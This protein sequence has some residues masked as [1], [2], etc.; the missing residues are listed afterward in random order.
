VEQSCHSVPC[1]PFETVKFT[2]TA[3]CNCAVVGYSNGLGNPD[4]PVHGERIRDVLAYY[5]TSEDFL[6]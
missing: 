1:P 5:E 3:I 6:P 2:V 4:C